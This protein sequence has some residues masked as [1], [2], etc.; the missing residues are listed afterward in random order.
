[1]KKLLLIIGISLL[2]YSCQKKQDNPTPSQT[3]PSQEP[4]TATTTTVKPK[5]KVTTWSNK[6]PY[7]YRR[8]TVTSETP[9]IA[10]WKDDTLRTNTGIF[11]EV[12]ANNQDYLETTVQVV[13]MPTVTVASI[14]VT[15][16]YL[17][18]KTVKKSETGQTFAVVFLKNVK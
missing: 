18:K 1:M 14:S 8:L 4:T 17:G 11:Y 6:L 3:T 15:A 13:S 2:A 10:V 9:F 16:E 5:V 12:M 7:I